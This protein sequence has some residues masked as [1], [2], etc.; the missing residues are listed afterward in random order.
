MILQRL[1]LL[2]GYKRCRRFHAILHPELLQQI[3][4]LGI[5]G[6]RDGLLLPVTCDFA[7]QRPLKFSEVATF[8]L[9]ED[10]LD[11]LRNLCR[12]TDYEEV[13]NPQENE[14]SAVLSNIQ[15]GVSITA[16][17]SQVVQNLDQ[18]FVPLA[19]S[20]LQAMKG[21]MQSPDIVGAIIEERRLFNIDLLF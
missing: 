3:A 8:E 20:L 5:L 19:S 12:F 13:V 14:T 6:H 1:H 9:S 10:G 7:A 4:D 2:S 17:E 21:F 18:S 15:T 11:Q 16:C